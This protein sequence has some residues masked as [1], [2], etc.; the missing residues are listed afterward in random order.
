MNKFTTILKNLII[1]NKFIIFIRTTLIIAMII[2]T[3]N[4]EWLT[5]FLTIISYIL[6]YF[7]VIFKKYSINLPKE[8]QSII[9]FFIYTSL[10]IWEAQD[11]YGKYSWW[12][13]LHH[14]FSWLALWF[15]GFL[16]LYIFYKSWKFQAPP[17]IIVIFSFCFALAI[18]ATWE[19]FEFSLD[20]FLWANWQKARYLC[21]GILQCNSRLWVMDT[22]YDLILDTIWAIIASTTWYI[23]LK[24][25]ESFRWFDSLIERFEELNKNL[26][27]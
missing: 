4:R 2:A 21:D 6:T 19:I 9:I 25:W 11:F 16:I 3:Y 23:F 7:Y 20:E 10:F 24:K 17:I 26:F 8:F 1:S 15:I 13:S 18:W 27:K 5:L 12:D 22:M 14:L